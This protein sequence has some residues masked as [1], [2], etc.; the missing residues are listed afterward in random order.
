VAAGL[1]SSLVCFQREDGFAQRLSRMAVAR[2]C[3][4]IE[5]GARLAWE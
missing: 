1:S 5:G 3:L 4:D 2:L